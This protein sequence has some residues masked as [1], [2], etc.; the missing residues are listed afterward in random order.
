MWVWSLALLSRLSIQHCC[1]LWYK[2]QMWLRS[3]VAVAVAYAGS[4]SSDST[5]SLRTSICCRCTLKKK[6]SSLKRLNTD[7]PYDPA[8]PFLDV[9]PKNENRLSSKYLESRTINIRQNTEKAQMHLL[10]DEWINKWWYIWKRTFL[11]EDSEVTK[12]ILYGLMEF[13]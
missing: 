2:S 1:K 7:L 13:V 3:Q 5:P 11:V 6:K 9:Y 8:I 4:C 10:K 12:S